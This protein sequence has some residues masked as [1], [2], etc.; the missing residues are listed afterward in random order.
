MR[1]FEENW[2]WNEWRKWGKLKLKRV[3]KTE[4]E[5]E[6]WEKIK[7]KKMS[8]MLV[9]CGKFIKKLK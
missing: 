3:K 9:K 4:I 8:K 7:K 6:I 1:K 2:N 5:N